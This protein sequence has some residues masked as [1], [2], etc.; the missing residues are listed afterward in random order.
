MSAQQVGRWIALAERGMVTAA[1]ALIQGF[2]RY[3][4]FAA[5]SRNAAYDAFAAEHGRVHGSPEEYARRLGIYRANVDFISRHNAQ[6]SKSHTL[7]VNHFADWS[8]VRNYIC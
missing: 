2:M 1:S 6:N 4:H 7:A 5:G 3:L 8:E